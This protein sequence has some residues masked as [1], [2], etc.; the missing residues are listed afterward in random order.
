MTELCNHEKVNGSPVGEDA[1]TEPPV[2]ACY[3]DPDR[4]CCGN[5]ENGCCGSQDGKQI[6]VVELEDEKGNVVVF[7]IMDE[8]TFEGRMF[9]ILA[10]YDDVIALEEAESDG[11]LSIG[12]FEVNGDDFSPLTDDDLA[13]RIVASLEAKAND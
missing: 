12:I 3:G 6:E 1:Q 13:G 11:D 8:L 5:H 2:R 10:P 4:P 7:A 9:A